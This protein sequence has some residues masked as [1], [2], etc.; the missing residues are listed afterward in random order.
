MRRTA[1]VLALCV[2]VTGSTPA[3]QSPASPQFEV[4]S[5]KRSVATDDDGSIGAQPNGRFV[6]RNVP[7]RFIVQVVHEVP[8]FRVTG[9]PDWIDSER[10]TLLHTVPTVVREL[11]GAVTPDRVFESMH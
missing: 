4:A 6:V 5:I 1:L 8:A 9:G 10:L 3:A 7:L 2:A 11:S